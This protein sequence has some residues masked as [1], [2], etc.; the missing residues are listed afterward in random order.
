MLNELI[1]ELHSLENP[2][3]AKIYLKF[4]KTKKGEYGEGDLFLGIKVPILRSIAKKYFSYF[5]LK[6]IE[7]LLENKYH[8]TRTVALLIL[9]LQYNKSKKD[10]IM[11][12]KIFEFYLNKIE[13]IN[14]WDLVDIS[15]P[16]IVGDFLLKY[17][18][19]VL[20]DLAK[21]ENLWKKRVAIISTFAFIKERNFGETLAIS[22]ILLNDEHD[23]INKAVGWMLREV[24]KRN[25]GILEI[26]LSTRY[27]SMPRTT[28]RYAIEKFPEDERKKWLKGE[29][30]E[31]NSL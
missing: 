13:R 14:N 22:N 15:A 21:S 20:M 6:E 2:A 3:Q 27:K 30:N 18:E 24:G 16:N 10:K 26:F 7:E 1:R 4:F 23:L 11:Q 29:I 8:E 9:M 28:L 25:K 19:D 17:K 12:R 31:K 5:S